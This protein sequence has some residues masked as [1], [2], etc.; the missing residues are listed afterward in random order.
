[1]IQDGSKMSLGVLGHVGSK[2]GDPP[3]D[4]LLRFVSRKDFSLD[5]EFV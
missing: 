5:P 2:L 3:T 4:K 1:M